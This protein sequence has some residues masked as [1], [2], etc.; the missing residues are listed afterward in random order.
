MLTPRHFHCRP[1][2]KVDSIASKEEVYKQI[3]Q[4]V[5]ATFKKLGQTP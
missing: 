3:K 5:D 2:H 4:A 1:L